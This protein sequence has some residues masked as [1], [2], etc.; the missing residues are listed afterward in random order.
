MKKFIVF[1]CAILALISVVIAMPLPAFA[2]EI[3]I[4]YGDQA[5]T[6]TLGG[7]WNQVATTSTTG[8]ALVDSTGAATTGPPTPAS[9]PFS[10]APRSPCPTTA[11]PA[12]ARAEADPTRRA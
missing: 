12:V 5:A 7:T 6:P 3:L 9:M 4:D 10:S 11:G 1:L 8:L 2:I